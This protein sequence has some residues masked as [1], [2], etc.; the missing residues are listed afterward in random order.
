[1]SNIQISPLTQEAEIPCMLLSLVGQTLLVPNVSV[2]EMAPVRPLV[3]SPDTPDWMLG[4]YEWR[5]LQVPVVSYELLSGMG[6]SGLNPNGRLAVLN[7]TGVS[8]LLPFIAIP[9]QSIPRIVRVSQDDIVE[10]E[11]AKRKPFD[12]MTV[13]VGVETLVIPDISAMES[14]YLNIRR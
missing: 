3:S 9:T 7:N 11:K 4:F 10:D 6:T 8:E 13:I 14:A 12:L 2:A 5:E 1:M